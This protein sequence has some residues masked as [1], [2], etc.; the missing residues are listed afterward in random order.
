MKLNKILLALLCTSAIGAT[1]QAQAGLI[2]FEDQAVISTVI[3]TQYQASHGVIFNVDINGN[4]PKVGGYNDAGLEGYVYN[5]VNGQNDPDTFRP[6]LPIEGLSNGTRFITDVIG[7][8]PVSAALSV[9][10]VNPVAAMSF[11]LLDIDG[12]QSF[13]NQGGGSTIE[14]Y[15]IQIFNSANTLLDTINISSG[16]ALS[17]VATGLDSFGKLVGDGVVSRF[18]FSRGVNEITHL[19]ITGS[20][21]AGGFGLAFD[22]FSTDTFTN[23]VPEP[24]SLALLGT[25][26]LGLVFARRRKTA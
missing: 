1:T 19:K 10:Y 16:V 17:G 25:G 6:G 3:T 5:P 18:G 15:T 2:T 7:I 21:P 9:T 11:D 4:T 13:L 12:Y 8:K 20:R 26:L 22:N 23:S 24:A 14:T